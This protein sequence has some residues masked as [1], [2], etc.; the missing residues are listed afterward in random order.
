MS[1]LPDSSKI[2]PGQ[3]SFWSL[4]ITVNSILPAGNESFLLCVWNH[5][6]PIFSLFEVQTVCGLGIHL[7][8]R[9]LLHL[10]TLLVKSWDCKDRNCVG[11][12]R[13]GQGGRNFISPTT[14]KSN[15]FTSTVLWKGVNAET[16]KQQRLGRLEASREQE[17]A[18]RRLLGLPELWFSLEVFQSFPAG[19][20]SSAASSSA[21]KHPS[22]QLLKFSVVESVACAGQEISSHR[23]LPMVWGS[24]G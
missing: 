6:A 14:S 24:D 5:S 3:C 11:R 21:V 17:K 20:L 22:E 1:T 7:T 4:N 16:I 2:T 10:K 15:S 9:L 23:G 8:L 12:K 18:A 13:K 19:T